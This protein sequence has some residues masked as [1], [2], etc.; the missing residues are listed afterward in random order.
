[1]STGNPNATGIDRGDLR[2]ELEMDG[3]SREQCGD[4]SGGI[5]VTVNS[6]DRENFRGGGRRM[7][8]IIFY[9]RCET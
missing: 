4:G 5:F 3:D 6:Q 8:I 9:L 7:A 1:V 2:G